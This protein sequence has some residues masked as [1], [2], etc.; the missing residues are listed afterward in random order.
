MIC[1]SQTFRIN[2]R[3]NAAGHWV[4][5]TDLKV[6][7]AVK[8]SGSAHSRTSWAFLLVTSIR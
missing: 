5:R 8:G 4:T 6:K 2:V 7:E 3:G 1:H